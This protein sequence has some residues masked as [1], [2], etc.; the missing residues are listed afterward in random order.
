MIKA[1]I[2]DMDDTLYLER[3]YVI[4]GFKAVDAFLKDKGIRGF[5][6]QAISLFEQGNRGKI[7]NEALDLLQVQYSAEDIK[8]LINVY[9]NHTPNIALDKDALE[10]LNY[11]QDKIPLGLI[12]DGYLVAQ[13]NKAAA[14]K[15]EMFMD[16]LIFT[17]EYGRE[18]WKP[19]KLPYEMMKDYFGCNHAELVYIGDNLSKDFVTPNKLG[20]TTV[21][22]RRSNGEYTKEIVKAG[23]EAQYLIDSLINLKE[24]INQINCGRSVIDEQ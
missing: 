21:R 17:D 7:F 3:D 6:N 22:L 24:I 2:F 15:L 23:Y 19:S 5:S 8:E 12:T 20:W 10:T 13:R 9:R 16:K 11:F 1:V 14:L 18:N 4:S